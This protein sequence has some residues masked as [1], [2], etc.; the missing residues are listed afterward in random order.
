MKKTIALLFLIFAFGYTSFFPILPVISAH[1]AGDF[2]RVITADTPLF[3]DETMTDFLFYL[4]YTYY[5]KV[6]SVDGEIAHIEYSGDF[7]PAVDG[8]TYLSMLYRD[9]LTVENPYPA[10]T[11]KTCKT[12]TFYSDSKLSEETRY[13]FPERNLYYYGSI[14]SGDEY[15]YCVSYNGNLG[16]VKEDCLYPFALNDHPNELTFLKTE[17]EAKETF[18]EEKEGNSEKDDPFVLRIIVIGCLVFAGLIAAFAVKKPKK[19]DAPSYY[20]END[21][22]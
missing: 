4:P 5:V 19:A 12:A 21:F 3:A 1:A 17:E 11:I 15:F 18:S 22:G 14:R 16:Y 13:I 6:I 10:L 2:M 7:A 20:D 9:E 8:Y